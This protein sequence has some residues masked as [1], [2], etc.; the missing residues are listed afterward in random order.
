MLKTLANRADTHWSLGKIF[1]AG[2]G[3]RTRDID[4]GKV[5]LYH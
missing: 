5:A 3:I 1:G 4:L 2:D